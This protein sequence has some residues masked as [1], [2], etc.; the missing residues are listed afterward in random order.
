MSTSG[1]AKPMNKDI[2]RAQ[3][4]LGKF[5]A[6][7]KVMN[8]HN[9]AIILQQKKIQEELDRASSGCACTRGAKIIDYQAQLTQLQGQLKDMTEINRNIAGNEQ[10][11]SGIN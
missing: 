6:E 5:Q 2:L 8:E 7:A 4:K 10:V 11:L 9:Q 3:R 1:Q